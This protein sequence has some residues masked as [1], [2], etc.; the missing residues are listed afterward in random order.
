MRTN[1]IERGVL[2]NA[3]DGMPSGAGTPNGQGDDPNVNTKPLFSGTTVEK[4]DPKTG[5]IIKIPIEM[6]SYIGH[7]ISTTRNSIENQYKPLVEKLQGD[8]TELS[9]LKAEY[10]KLKEAN[11]TVEEKAR[12]DAARKIA[13]HEVTAKNAQKDAEKWQA[14]YKETT[15]KNDILASFGDTKLHNPE[16]VAILMKNEGRARVEEVLDDRVV[17]YHRPVQQLLTLK[18]KVSAVDDREKQK[19]FSKSFPEAAPIQ[20]VSTKN[21]PEKYR[22]DI[23]IV[24]DN[25]LSVHRRLFNKALSSGDFL[26]EIKFAVSSKGGF[27]ATAVEDGSMFSGLGLQTGDIIKA[28]NDSELNSISDVMNIYRSMD[29]MT[30]LELRLERQGQDVFYYYQLHDGR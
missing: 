14:L 21:I 3:D 1:L 28:V 27:Q 2:L 22:E 29:N 20:G 13:E 19:L 23:N 16:Q 4:K 25:M 17:V 15:I 5:E 24:S 18:H 6:E 11:M 8:N 26:K 7:I 12:A 10:D 30:M 9:E